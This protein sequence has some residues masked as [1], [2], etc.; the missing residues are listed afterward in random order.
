MANAV[1]SNASGVP[2]SLRSVLE[3]ITETAKVKCANTLSVLRKL[4]DALTTEATVLCAIAQLESGA[5]MDEVHAKVSKI[6]ARFIDVESK[7]KRKRQEEMLTSQHP[8]PALCR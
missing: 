1:G 5:Y 7:N 8:K 4:Q 6:M 2:Y 3:T